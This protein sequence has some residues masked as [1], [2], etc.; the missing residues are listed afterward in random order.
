[1][2]IA[3]DHHGLTLLCAQAKAAAEV[4]AALQGRTPG[5]ADI[6]SLPYVE[7]VVLEALR[8]YAPA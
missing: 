8:L 2:A 1:M 6:R 3:D 7:A 4:A 5:A